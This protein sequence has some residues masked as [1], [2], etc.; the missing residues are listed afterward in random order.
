MSANLEEVAAEVVKRAMSLGASDAECTAAEGA[1]FSVS[2]RKGEVEKLKEAGSK[3]IGL[4]V[5]MGQKQGSAY[6]S[7]LSKEGLEQMVRAAVE[8]AQITS[9]DPH[10]GLPDPSELG[11][12]EGDLGL[13]FEETALV[14]ADE[15]IAYAKRAEAAAMSADERIF[16]SEGA[17][18]GSYAGQRVF[19]NSRGFVGSYRSSTCS[20]SATP[21]AKLGEA[22]E[23][24][25]W[26]SMARQFSKLESPEYVGKKAAARALR[27][28]GARKV[29]TQKA[30]II[31]DTTV[32]RS[33]LD[34][35]FDAASG[36]SIYRKSSF[37]VDKLGESIASDKLTLV[38]DATLP[39]T[40][41]A[42]PFDDEGVASRR[43][44]ILERTSAES[45][46]QCCIVH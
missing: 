19:A 35:I 18:F 21:V 16:N 20:L 8:L 26:Y 5:L 42:C 30:P 25:Y 31:F 39:G 27:R 24:D 29:D 40:F 36:D 38:D 6:T 2:V 28:L 41:G 32:A 46:R 22:M 3:A 13:F 34:H 9:E 44:L 11:K 17:G 15:K 45:A 7:D 4:R 37:L 12:I 1:E 33:L 14:P 10:A 23:R 43:T